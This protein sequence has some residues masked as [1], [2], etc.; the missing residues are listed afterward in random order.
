V[1][2]SDFIVTDGKEIYQTG[3]QIIPSRLSTEL[4]QASTTQIQ[5]LTFNDQN[6]IASLVQ[7]RDNFPQA[8][9]YLTGTLQIDLPEDVKL[10]NNSDQYPS[11]TLTGTTLKLDYL[12]IEKAI[13]ILKE[14]YAIG[15]LSAKIV[16]GGQR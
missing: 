3:K 13:A 14:E 5:T 9:I 10:P 6:A 4:G 15:S 11:A 2:G 1:E 8:Q 16:T 12:P 7:L